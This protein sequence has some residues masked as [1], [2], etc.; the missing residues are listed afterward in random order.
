MF[1]LR[2]RAPKLYRR[3]VVVA[4]AVG[5]F[6]LG[7]LVALLS[8]TFW[9]Q[10]TVS[11]T[12]QAYFGVD[13]G[14]GDAADAM[15]V[16]DKV[17]GY[18]NLIVLGS[19]NLTT[20][21]EKLTRVCD[22]IY[23]KGLHF[24]IYIGFASRGY[25]P[26]R[27]PTSEFFTETADRWGDK[28][29]GIYLFDEV[30]GKLIDGAHSINLTA[31]TSYTDAASL[32][33][34][35]LNYYQGNVTMFYHASP[36]KL[37]T[38]DYG[39][40]WYDYLAG[41]D[42]VLSEFAGNDSR[43]IAIG[44]C[45]GAAKTLDKEWGTMITWKYQQP[46]YLEEGGQLYDDLVLAYQNG[47]KYIVV[48]N[49]PGFHPSETNASMLIEN[50][51]LTE[52]GI[53]TAEHLDAMKRFWDYMQTHSR[54]GNYPAETAYVLPADYGYGFRGPDDSIWGEWK[55]DSLSPVVWN[56]V[57]NL[58]AAYGMDLDIVY[59]SE[60]GYFPIQLP[61]HKLIYWNGTIVNQA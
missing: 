9:R 22:Y 60:I 39:L 49:S 48:F 35:H 27:G 28:F 23:Q 26:P 10:M 59:E 1:E 42:V 17:A 52:Y 36:V 13:I 8:E 33:V 6:V 5:F 47:A 55:A 4:A 7:L 51:T 21:T 46:P 24:I 2:P 61:Y 18:T 58:L 56:E 50:P 30:G 14:Y 3:R 43:N 40:Y 57:N 20:D 54:S 38:S 19:L 41:Y 32:Y 11:R 31:A 37:F 15:K 45:R 44:L 25:T 16:V 29:L 53:L 12:P 34:H